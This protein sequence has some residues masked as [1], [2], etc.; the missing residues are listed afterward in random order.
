MASSSA[1]T[2]SGSA[3]ETRR[4]IK[5]ISVAAVR[6]GAVEVGGGWGRLG[7]G[8]PLRARF[9]SSNDIQPS[10]TFSPA[11]SPAVSSMAFSTSRR[12]SRAVA[13]STAARACPNA[14]STFLRASN[15]RR[16]SLHLPLARRQLRGPRIEPLRVRSHTLIARAELLLLRVE[17]PS[18]CLDG[19][20][21]RVQLPL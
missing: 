6:D 2:S 4:P 1:L 18:P 17:L 9:S 19:G 12:A 7:E 16:A 11:A 10:L 13:S 21:Q 8:D 14:S 20:E 3:S 15:A 5:E